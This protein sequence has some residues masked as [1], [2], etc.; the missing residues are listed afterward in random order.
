M[1]YVYRTFATLFAVAV[2]FSNIRNAR[3]AGEF[4]IEAFIECE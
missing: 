1:K 4:L 3:H 2:V